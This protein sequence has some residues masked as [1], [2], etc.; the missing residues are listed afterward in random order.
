VFDE[1]VGRRPRKSPF[2]PDAGTQELLHQAKGQEKGKRMLRITI[3]LLPGGREDGKRVIA[4][5]DVVRLSDGPIAALA[6]YKVALDDEMLGEVG[7]QIVVHN[8]P[9]WATS[10]WDLVARCIAA[11]LNH[12]REV[13]PPRPVQPKVTVRT[14]DAGFR[15][16]RLDEIPEPTRTFF[17]RKLTG[18]GVPDHDCAYAHDWFDF[19]EGH[20]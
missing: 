18:S 10:V 5:A 1:E 2:R 6:E 12:G 8:Y 15:Y 17:D 13:L 3:E 7:E 11:A 14:N 9:R 20:R 19:L 16:V 4:T